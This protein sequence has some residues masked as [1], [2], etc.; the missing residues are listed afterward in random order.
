MLRIEN[1]TKRFG[2]LLVVDGVLMIVEPGELRAV[3][4]CSCLAASHQLSTG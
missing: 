4:A 1:V 3:M 2:S